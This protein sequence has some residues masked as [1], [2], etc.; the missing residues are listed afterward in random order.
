MSWQVAAKQICS[1]QAGLSQHA[2]SHVLTLVILNVHSTSR[3]CSQMNAMQAS[4][5]HTHLV[6]QPVI[7]RTAHEQVLRS[8]S[9]A[10]SQHAGLDPLQLAAFSSLIDALLRIREKEMQACALGIVQLCCDQVSMPM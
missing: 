5:G 10:S 4:L 2:Q 8:A 9:R 6:L 1:S 7:A 3:L